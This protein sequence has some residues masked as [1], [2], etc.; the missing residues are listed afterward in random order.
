MKMDVLIAEYALTYGRPPDRDMPWPLF[1]LL[2]SRANAVFARRLLAAMHG[3]GWAI[4][5]AFGGKQTG[6][7]DVMRRD[8]E[9][10]AFPDKSSKGPVFAL[11][12]SK[13]DGDG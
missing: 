8:I 6:A 5:K 3:T 13:E 11:K 9:R 1:Q 4:G 7:L 12:Q 10:V 2:L